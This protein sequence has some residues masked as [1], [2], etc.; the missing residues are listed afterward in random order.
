MISRRGRQIGAGRR[1]LAA[2]VLLTCLAGP[3]A[4]TFDWW[5]SGQKAGDDTEANFVV[6][7]LCL[8]G[9]MMAA[10]SCLTRVISLFLRVRPHV[11]VAADRFISVDA[12]P[13]R[14][15]EITV[16]PPLALRI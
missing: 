10:R 7:A 12:L 1:L 16:S 15:P 2:I 14:I 11:H 4:E 13:Y 8:G 3:I 6:V 9:A 5:D